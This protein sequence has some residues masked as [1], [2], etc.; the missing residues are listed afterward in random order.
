MT[1]AIFA[2]EERDQAAFLLLDIE[3]L[4]HARTTHVAIDKQYALAKLRQRDGQIAYHSGLA[5]TRFS[6]D[7]RQGTWRAAC[8][9][10]QD[11]GS[12][13]AERFREGGMLS[14]ISVD[15]NPCFSRWLCQ[16]TK[17]SEPIR[18]SIS[19]RA[20]TG[21]P[22]AHQPVHGRASVTQRFS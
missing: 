1:P 8:G 5:F 6:T 18:V 21:C 9:R 20:V 7:K 3:Q 11:R 19:V 10:K 15:A 22:V 14:A 17:V 13:S 2:R 4:V 16:S 12:Q